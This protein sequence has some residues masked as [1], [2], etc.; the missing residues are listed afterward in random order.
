[1]S[2]PRFVKPL[3]T[4]AADAE[5]YDMMSPFGPLASVRVDKRLGGIIQFWTEEDA[6]MA[7][8]AVK[9][10]FPLNLS[11]EV[12]AS[13]LKE[14]FN[15]YSSVT[16]A[17]I[18][19]NAGG[20]S[21]GFGFVTFSNPEDAA[22]AIEKLDG[23]ELRSK[24]FIDPEDRQNVP[25]SPSETSSDRPRVLKNGILEEKSDE[26]HQSSLVET[27]LADIANLKGELAKEKNTRHS[28]T[29][30]L[31]TLQGEKEGLEERAG[32]AE[33]ALVD[34]SSL[35]EM[36]NG[37]LAKEKDDRHREMDHITKTLDELQGEKD[38]LEER[39]GKA[40]KAL[41]DKT[42]R[43]EVETEGWVSRLASLQTKLADLQ[44]RHQDELDE[45]HSQLSVVL[46]GKAKAEEFLKQAEKNRDEWRRNFE[47]SDSRRKILELETDR[48]REENARKEREQSRKAEEAESA[49]K[50]AEVEEAKCRK[51]GEKLKRER[52]ETVRKA[53]E[54]AAAK[55]K[56]RQQ[57]W[58]QA[59]DAEQQRCYD[60][61][62]GII[63]RHAGWGRAAARERFLL[64]VEEFDKR[65]FSE[66]QPITFNNIP[67]PVL[68]NPLCENTNSEIAW[69][70][71][72]D[73]FVYIRVVQTVAD[74][75]KL[76]E[77]VHR[78]F[79]PDKWRSRRLLDTVRCPKLRRTLEASGNIVAQAMSPL[80]SQTK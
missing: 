18:V 77:K 29:K 60:R 50:K 70:K 75:K 43:G 9:A 46:E 37:Q 56:V 79:H 20:Q 45:L 44:S 72:E 40:K 76:V 19:Y 6:L 61:D 62:V 65:K 49:R 27:L 10:T 5:L 3:P 80:W 23:I 11:F 15:K 58:M 14:H 74:Y 39:A 35:I 21:R 59:T 1:M 8:D 69:Q 38:Q 52:E 42:L 64:V 17:R 25:S 2:Y 53:S 66:A 28:I 41:A 51:M 78:M 4:G 48:L 67:W 54:A 33:K 31:D 34:K 7:E 16:S 73:F 13:Q 26:N 47:L 32:N 71:V 24:I 57:A 68:D 30:M 55:E 12:N 22:K 63:G 36:L